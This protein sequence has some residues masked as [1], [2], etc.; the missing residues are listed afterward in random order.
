MQKCTDGSK[1]GKQHEKGTLVWKARENPGPQHFSKFFTE[2]ETQKHCSYLFHS[3]P[4]PFCPHPGGSTP[5]PPTKIIICSTCQTQCENMRTTTRITV[6]SVD[7]F[8]EQRNTEVLFTLPVLKFPSIA[9]IAVSVRTVLMGDSSHA[10]FRRV[11]LCMDLVCCFCLPKV[12]WVAEAFK[13]R[14]YSAPFH[15]APLQLAL[16]ADC[17]FHDFAMCSS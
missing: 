12:P 14:V 15:K 6:T 17:W 5:T 3:F 7:I 10:C 2:R 11:L 9:A 4:K 1:S 16:P 8:S 13:N